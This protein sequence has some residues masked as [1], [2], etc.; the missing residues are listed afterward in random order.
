[1]SLWSDYF[2]VPTLECT[3]PP[4][5]VRLPCLPTAPH[6]LIDASSTLSS[7]FGHA[8]VDEYEDAFAMGVSRQ[9][10]IFTMVKS[11]L[12]E[13]WDLKAH[14]KE[15]VAAAVARIENDGKDGEVYVHIRHGD[16]HPREY[17]FHRSY[18]PLERYF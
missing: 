3:P 4:W 17:W 2:H 13:I 8:F 1:S 12:N 7:D 11:G 9:R 5:E 6:R 15:R 14:L 16:A 10:E 18:V